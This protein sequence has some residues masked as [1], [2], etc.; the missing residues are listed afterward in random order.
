MRQKFLL[1]VAA[2]IMLAQ[3]ISAAVAPNH[4]EPSLIDIGYGVKLTREQ[5]LTLTPKEFKKLTGERLGVKRA[6]ALKIM[7][8]QAK[9]EAEGKETNKSQVVAG[10]LC[11]FLGVLGIHRFYLG[12]TGIGIVQLLTAGGFG[13]WALIDLIMICTGDL[14]PKGG[15]YKKSN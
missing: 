10:V 6:V 1:I 15:E 8:K 12:Y 4:S 13:I 2:F 11:F 3:P 9:R 7:Q 5:F 14:K